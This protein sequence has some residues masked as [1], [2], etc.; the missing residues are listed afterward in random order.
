LSRAGASNDRKVRRYHKR[1]MVRFGDG[2]VLNC[3]GVIEN[4]SARGLY[5][6]SSRIYSPGTVLKIE[7][8]VENEAHRLE[9]EVR[10][11]RRAPANLIRVVPS[12]MGIQIR[13]APEAFY[14]LLMALESQHDDR[15]AT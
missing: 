9:G 5:L 10:W 14:Y 2:N 6:T 15:A 1:V 13:Q 12:G 7:F 8:H 3:A 4:V 11:A